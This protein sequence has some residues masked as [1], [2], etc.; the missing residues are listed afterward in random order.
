MADLP[1]IAN[2]QSIITILAHIG[3]SI[4]ISFGIKNNN[5]SPRENSPPKP[6][7]TNINPTVIMPREE[8]TRFISFPIN[9]RTPRPIA[10][11]IADIERRS[12]FANNGFSIPSLG[13]ACTPV[14]I[15]N[16]VAINPPIIAQCAT[17]TFVAG[18]LFKKQSK[19]ATPAKANIP[20]VNS[21]EITCNVPADIKSIHLFA[22]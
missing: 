11:P 3:N 9:Q 10:K 2:P 14:M 4:T 5:V 15:A 13:V 18:P 22:D 21:V 19:N 16:G 1:I 8:C 20:I 6:A 17:A 12:L 7:V